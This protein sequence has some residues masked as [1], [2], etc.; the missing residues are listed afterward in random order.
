M[1]TPD[2]ASSLEADPAE[3]GGMKKTISNAQRLANH[4]AAT[5]TTSGTDADIAAL[6]AAGRL[7]LD[8]AL[9]LATLAGRQKAIEAIHLQLDALDEAAM[10]D[11]AASLKAT[12]GS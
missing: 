7:E 5:L 1:E 8:A 10:D 2:S 4:A 12:F 11:F 6:N 3:I 9:D